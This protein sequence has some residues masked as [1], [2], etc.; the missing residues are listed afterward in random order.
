MIGAKWPLVIVV[1]AIVVFCFV[2]RPREVQL[3]SPTAGTTIRVVGAYPY[4][5]KYLRSGQTSLDSNI[6]IAFQM[7]DSKWHVVVNYKGMILNQII[8]GSIPVADA[9]GGQIEFPN[10]AQITLGDLR[11]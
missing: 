9:I 8:D 5:Y 11:N 10:I 1:C 7:R 6:K 4:F 3:D 2:F